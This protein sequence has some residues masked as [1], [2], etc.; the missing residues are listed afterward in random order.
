MTGFFDAAV[1]LGDRIEQG[2]TLGTVCDILGAEKQTVVADK[3]GIV[4]VL[5]TFCRVREGTGLA[6]ILETD[7]NLV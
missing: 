5:H 6:V 7:H 2:D 4:L 1:R 3:S